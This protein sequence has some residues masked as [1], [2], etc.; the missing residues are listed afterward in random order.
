MQGTGSA[1][2]GYGSLCPA[3][4][5]DYLLKLWDLRALGKEVGAEYLQDSIDVRLIYIL[6]SVW[7]HF[8]VRG[9]IQDP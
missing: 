4:C 1:I 6:P 2:N 7:N 5:G 8:H 3:I 9:S